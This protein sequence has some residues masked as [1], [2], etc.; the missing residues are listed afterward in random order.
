[1]ANYT[2]FGTNFRDD[3]KLVECETP[4]EAIDAWVE[5][6]DKYPTCVDVEAINQAQAKRL[7]KHLNNNVVEVALNVQ[8]K[9]G[10]TIDYIIEANITVHKRGLDNIDLTNNGL[11]PFTMG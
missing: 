8:N 3:I 11:Y 6:Q 9:T 1:M 5:L 2:V 7:Y 10:F 4:Q